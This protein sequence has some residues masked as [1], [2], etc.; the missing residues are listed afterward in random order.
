MWP[1]SELVVKRSLEESPDDHPHARSDTVTITRSYTTLLD[2]TLAVSKV[3]LW[4]NGL[5]CECGAVRGD[6]M[7]GE[8]NEE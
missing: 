7:E 8:E 3:I 6:P 4:H 1:S 5:I 2:S